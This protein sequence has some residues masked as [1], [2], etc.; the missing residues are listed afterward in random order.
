M[1]REASPRNGGRFPEV[2]AECDGAI[3]RALWAPGFLPGSPIVSISPIPE[4]EIADYA[5][6]K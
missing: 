6:A 2:L 3:L 5:I 4:T 1:P